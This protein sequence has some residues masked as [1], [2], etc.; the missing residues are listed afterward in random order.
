MPAETALYKT[1]IKSGAKMVDFAGYKMP[2]EY[3]GIIREHHS[4][5]TSAGLFDVS[6]MGQ[7]IVRGSNSLDFLQY[8]TSNDVSTLF[9]GKAQ[10]TCFPNG[11]GGI[12]DDLLI[13]K[14]KDY[15]L[16]VVNASNIKKDRD[17]LL[18]NKPKNTEF[19]DVSDEYSQIAIQGPKAAAII[20]TLTK[21]DVS[22]LKAFECVTCK[23]ADKH[24]V[25][26]SRTGYTGE[27]GFEIYFP[28]EK[29]ESLWESIMH[30]GSKYD[31]Q[32]VGLGARDTL[33]LEA[34]L[35]LYGN[36]IDDTT[37]PLEAGLEWITKLN[38]KNDFIDKQF[39]INQKK[40]GI[41]RILIGFKMCEKGIPR[42][43]YPIVNKKGETIGKVTSGTMSPTLK[44]GIGMGYIPIQY[45]KGENDIFI[46]IRNRFIKTEITKLPFI[47]KKNVSG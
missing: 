46:E 10:Y 42:K 23:I 1:H 12:V 24:D 14:I 34:G 27:D 41:Q 43:G 36:E 26:L 45:A 47:N 3:N 17:F 32:P 40:N 33:R 11:S 28:D 38:K 30:A 7:F 21:A 6:H 19:I 15:F 39:L 16:L 4:V 13:Y 2:V 25:I 44:Q 18:A 9:S 29:A 22:R 5:R 31:I 20:Q 8:V 37:S 35:Y